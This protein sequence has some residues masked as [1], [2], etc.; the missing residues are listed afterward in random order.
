[1]IFRT[2][3]DLLDEFPWLAPKEDWSDDR[4]DFAEGGHWTEI[5]DLPIGWK[6]GFLEEM[7]YEIDEVIKDYDCEADYVVIET[8]A[9]HGQLFW[10]HTGFP[11]EARAELNAIVKAYQKTSVETCMT[12]GRLGKGYLVN[13]EVIIACDL[14]KPEE[15]DI[16][17]LL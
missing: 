4:L 1:M 16:D 6:E 10:N 3:E 11:S 8:H 2:T 14:H 12:C 7:L 5:D 17:V 15:D 9:K 13:G